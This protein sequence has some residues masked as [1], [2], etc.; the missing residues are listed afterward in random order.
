M[1]NARK[2][3]QEVK[4]RVGSRNGWTEIPLCYKFPKNYTQSP[5][6]HGIVKDVASILGAPN[7]ALPCVGVR[8]I[9]ALNL[10]KLF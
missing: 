2:V 6:C 5:A 7:P 8:C 3:L 4:R 9:A 10:L 1:S